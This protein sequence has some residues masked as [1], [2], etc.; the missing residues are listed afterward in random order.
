[1]NVRAIGSWAVAVAIGLILFVVPIAAVVAAIV[2]LIAG[3]LGSD[4][5]L[6]E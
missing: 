5:T 2:I 1:M 6:P 4:R 3:K